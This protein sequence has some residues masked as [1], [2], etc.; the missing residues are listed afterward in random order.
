MSVCPCDCAPCPNWCPQLYNR[1]MA[2]STTLPARTSSLN[3]AHTIQYTCC[4]AP[5]QVATVQ[6][7]AVQYIT[8]T[9]KILYYNM[10]LLQY[11]TVLYTLSSEQLV[12]GDDM[13]DKFQG[14]T[15]EYT[16]FRSSLLAPGGK[17]KY[18]KLE[19]QRLLLEV[20]KIATVQHRW[21]I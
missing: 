1:S 6:Y 16:N 10:G 20:P 4:T 8:V 9:W 3:L 14:M 13:S 21:Y 11:S 18:A 7:K 15:V 2:D 12:H 5:T 19:Q 17:D